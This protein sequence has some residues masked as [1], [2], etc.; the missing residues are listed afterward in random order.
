MSVSRH[1]AT[2]TCLQSYTP[3]QILCMVLVTPPT[4]MTFF[5]SSAMG[6]MFIL[7]SLGAAAD[8]S[9]AF[10]MM[11]YFLFAKGGCM[12]YT[13]QTQQ[14]LRAPA[15]FNSQLEGNNTFYSQGAVN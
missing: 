9:S 4:S 12:G 5:S 3:A 13:L 7:L 15:Y 1:S 10:K 11:K 2:D 6:K 8:S 14:W